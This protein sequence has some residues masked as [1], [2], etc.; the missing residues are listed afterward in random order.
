M[1]RA[2]LRYVASVPATLY[3]RAVVHSAAD[4]FAEAVLVADGVVVWLGPDDVADRIAGDAEVVDLGGALITPAFVDAHAHVRL[5]GLADGGPDLAGRS[6]DDLLDA[7]SRAGGPVVLGYGWTADGREPPSPAALSRASRGRAVL[8]LAA[9][10]THALATSDLVPGRA[11]DSSALVVGDELA[12]ALVT[13]GAGVPDAAGRGLAA[14]AAAGIVAV[15]EH[16]VPALEPRSALADLIG[17][18]A[19]DASRVPLVLGHRAE[20]CETADDA[21]DLLDAVP[22][23]VAIGGDLAVDGPVQAWQAALR[24]GYADAPDRAGELRLRPEQV[25]NHIAPPRG[26]TPGGPGRRPCCC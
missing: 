26:R 7:V 4:P 25:A 11:E 13:L 10:L 14:A 6:G 19:D 9:D 12:Q 1:L 2:A 8:L 17:A 22:G 3:R 23:L 15:H 5:S 18:T 20:L 16:S 24:T 21:R